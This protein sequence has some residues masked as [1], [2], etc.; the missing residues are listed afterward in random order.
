MIDLNSYNNESIDLQD[1]I[2]ELTDKYSL[3][4]A[5]TFQSLLLEHDVII[6]ELNELMNE[7]QKNIKLNNLSKS[8]NTL[9]TE[10]SYNVTNK[11]KNVINLTKKKKIESVTKKRKIEFIQK[12]VTSIKRIYLILLWSYIICVF[13]ALFLFIKNNKYTTKKHIFIMC[14]FI[15]FIFVKKYVYNLLRLILN[16]FHYESYHFPIYN[17]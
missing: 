4:N 1:T 15:I 16:L 9:M 14:I 6:T 13:M 11:Q 17:L 8:K 2:E 12:E 7:T 10:M 5:I 3:K